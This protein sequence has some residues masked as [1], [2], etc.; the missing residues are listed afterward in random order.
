MIK[1]KD[2]AITADDHCYTVGKPVVRKDKDGEEKE[3]IVKPRYYTTLSDAVRGLME[4]MRKEIVAS[5]D[6]D[7]SGLLEAVEKSDKA[8][9][10][11]LGRGADR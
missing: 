11:C 10:D 1:Y 3:V 5:G 2:Y 8:V 9:L 7:L 6:M 4:S